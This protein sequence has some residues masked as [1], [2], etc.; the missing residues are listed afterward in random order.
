M[1]PK[2]TV[3]RRDHNEHTCPIKSCPWRL[4]PQG[5]CPDHKVKAIPNPNYGSDGPDRRTQTAE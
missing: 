3:A 5:R 4:G 2:Q 1:I